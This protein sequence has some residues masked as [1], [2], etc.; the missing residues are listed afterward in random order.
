MRNTLI[1]FLLVSLFP[2]VLAQEMSGDI[3][4]YLNEFVDDMPGSSGNDY[5]VPSTTELTRW[6]TMLNY[7]FDD[8]DIA[9]ARSVAATFNY[10]IVV[11]TDNTLSANNTFILIEEK[12]PQTK[13][14]GSYVI[15]QSPLRDNL[16]LQAPHPQ[17]DTNTGKQAVYCFKRL[18]PLALFISGT[19]RCNHSQSSVCSGTAS[20]CGNSGPYRVSDNPHNVTSVFHRATEVLSDKYPNS[21]FIQ[22]HGF[23]KLSSDP[24]LIMSNGTR[25]TP[26]V[27]YCSLIKEALLDVDNTLTFKI[28]HIDQSWT[29]LIAF[30]NTQ[31]RYINNSSNPCT[32]NAT[33]TEGRFV[34][35]EQERTKLR[36]NSE[37]WEKMYLAL[38][39]VF[40]VNTTAIK[41]FDK[42]QANLHPN[43]NNGVFKVEI[44]EAGEL[45]IYNTNSKRVY[46]QKLKHKE[47]L[48]V[49]LSAETPGLY[50]LIVKY[51]TATEYAKVLIY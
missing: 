24:Y 1:L 40:D 28:A 3:E 42:Q 51:K 21:I 5:S 9:S 50:A 30:T 34:H 14:W 44:K 26:T 32:S 2:A 38:K 31:G 37:G 47:M 39:E 36:S 19:H 48:T 27:D 35:I 4:S 12:T 17:Y 6:E 43:P 49:D 33:T 18:I 15:S 16:V 20:V 7:L 45:S 25:V 13:Y 29:R 11:F 22:L 10:Q 8:N 41:T 46:H 23:A